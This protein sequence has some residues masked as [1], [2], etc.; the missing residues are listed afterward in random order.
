MKYF[1][2]TNTAS[3]SL[4]VIRVLD[5]RGYEVPLKLGEF[6]VGPCGLDF[7]DEKI[8]VAN[9]YNN[10][11][12]IVDLALQKEVK[13]YYIGGAPLNL[14]VNRN[15]AYIICGESNFLVGYNIE[16]EKIDFEV[17]VGENPQSLYIDAIKNLAYISSLEE[18]TIAIIDL[19]ERKKV[20]TINLLESPT[21]I[22]SSSSNKFLYICESYLG[23]DKK[24][25]VAVYSIKENRVLERFEVGRAPSDIFEGKDSFYISN[26][27]E[28]SITIVNKSTLKESS[29]IAVGGMP[30]SV[31]KEEEIL[32]VLDNQRG[33]IK[34]IDVMGKINKIIAVGKEPSAMILVT[35]SL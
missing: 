21:K 13:N 15:T 4:N 5:L 3:N 2:I 22:I 24:G 9:K 33:I 1:V 7:N 11:I 10:S 28:G 32:Y 6:P 14:K 30:I 12:S 26:L 8:I 19:N 23:S 31:I 29:K 17:R 25:T 34:A 18:N 20:S 16:K 27:G 35:Q